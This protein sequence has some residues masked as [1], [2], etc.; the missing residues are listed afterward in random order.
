MCNE[1]LNLSPGICFVPCLQPLHIKIVIYH[2][3]VEIG[4]TGI[5][6]ERVEQQVS[7]RCPRDGLVED[8]AHMRQRGVCTI[9]PRHIG[10][11]PALPELF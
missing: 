8:V 2:D 5:V 11:L 9:L 1:S 7:A 6:Y 4:I 3:V 10:R